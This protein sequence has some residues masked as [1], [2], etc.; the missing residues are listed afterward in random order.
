MSSNSAR[1]LWM[2]I[3]SFL[4]GISMG[5]FVGQR[6]L[7][8]GEAVDVALDHAAHALV[9]GPVGGGQGNPDTARPRGHHH[10]SRVG[11]GKGTHPVALVVTGRHLVAPVADEMPDVAL[12]LL[13]T[14]EALRRHR[15]F[16]LA[17]NPRSLSIASSRW[18]TRLALPSKIMCFSCSEIS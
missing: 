16:G 12:G 18:Y 15:S 17:H 2:S 11:E 8:E 13:A 6:G 1:Y 7:A 14:G 3:R 10:A 9:L 4:S 5:P